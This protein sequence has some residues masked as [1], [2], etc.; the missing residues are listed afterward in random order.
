[1]PRPHQ[2]RESRRSRSV[3]RTP[4]FQLRLDSLLVRKDIPSE[5]DS[6][7]KWR[8]WACCR[9][10]SRGVN[11]FCF[12]AP[13]YRVPPLC[14]VPGSSTHPSSIH[15]SPARANPTISFY[16]PIRCFLSPLV[17]KQS[18]NSLPLQGFCRRRRV[19]IQTSFSRSLIVWLR[20]QGAVAQ[21]GESEVL[22]M[23]C[24]HGVLNANAR[25]RNSFARCKK[26]EEEIEDGE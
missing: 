15:S 20:C 24:N 25:R 23:W 14:D 17:S 19:E 11:W 10:G 18:L 12:P 7:G 16:D 1:M 2:M 8:G 22:T 9:S 13:P 6:I 26:E 5:F 4:S 3:R 21:N